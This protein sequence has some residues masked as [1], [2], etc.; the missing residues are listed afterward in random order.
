[1]YD[2]I[3]TKLIERGIPA[4]EIAFIHTADT[5][6][7]KKALYDDVNAGRVRIIFGSTEKLGAGTNIQRLLYA[8]HDLDAPW[9]PRDVEQRKGRIER[10]GNK[11]P[12]IKIFRYV[13]EGSFDAY[14]WQGLETKVRFI[15]QVMTG[16]VTV[17]EAE[18]LES[19]AL[20][21]AEIKAI[22]SGNPAVMEKV[23]IDTEVRKLDMLR[24]AHRN[25]HYEI[26]RQVRD[27]PARIENPRECYAGLLEDISTRD[28][29]EGEF[30]MTVDGRVFSGKQ[31]REEAGKA[32]I[33][34]ITAS[35]WEDS[36]ELKL[37]RLGDYKGFAIMSS[38]SGREGEAPRLYLRGRHTYEA[39]LNTESASGTIASIEY[40]L[41]RLDRDAEE[42]KS[43]CERMEKALAEYREQLNRPFE[44]E[45]RLRGLCARQQ[46]INR[47]LDLDKGD[48]QAV[49]N[50]NMPQ[51]DRDAG[52]F[53]ERLTAR[54]TARGRVNSLEGVA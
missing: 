20:T 10:Q 54:G 24:S 21:F 12:F 19:G 8:E 36:R 50:D 22:A 15:G 51:D 30:V 40:A 11:N 13:T 31:A 27:L 39:N 46:E 49:A 1:M 32:L 4:N 33:Q 47:Q 3:R 28:A 25:Q 38:F 17:R 41:R 34:S 43:K 7:K 23:R 16:D 2:E 42:E 14:M 53:V 37:K 5:D 48:V 29:H 18:D 6:A 9:R 52:T 35:L 26:S 44:H 45:E